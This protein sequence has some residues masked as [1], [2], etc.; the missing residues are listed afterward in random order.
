MIVRITLTATL[1]P[2]V[3]PGAGVGAP[4]VG[5]SPA[6]AEAESAHANAIA[7]ANRFIVGFLL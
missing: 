4:V 6:K 7:N 3:L 5:T 1:G 2:W